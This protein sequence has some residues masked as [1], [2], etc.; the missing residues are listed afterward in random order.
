MSVV[1]LEELVG[2]KIRLKY[3][4]GV[5]KEDVGIELGAKRRL[6]ASRKTS[7]TDEYSVPDQGFSKETGNFSY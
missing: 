2:L 5:R 4:R 1:S 6:F 3:N 7:K